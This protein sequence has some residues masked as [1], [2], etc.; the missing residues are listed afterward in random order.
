MDEQNPV[1][2]IF[3]IFNYSRWDERDNVLREMNICES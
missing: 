2:Y 1:L 3:E